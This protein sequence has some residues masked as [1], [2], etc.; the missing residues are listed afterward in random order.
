[1]PVDRY[2][3]SDSARSAGEPAIRNAV[4]SRAAAILRALGETADSGVSTTELARTLGLP[5]ATVHRLMVALS[6]EGLVD[7][8]PD[9][10]RWVLGLEMYVL[11]ST[12]ALRYDIATAAGE[13]LRNLARATGESAF[14]SVRRGDETVVLTD[15]EGTF[16]LRSHVLHPGKRLPLGVASA[17]LVLLA[18]LPDAEVDRYLDHVDLAAGWGPK[19]SAANVRRRLAETRRLGYSVNPGLLVEGSWGIG[20]A[21][22]NRSGRPEWALSLTGVQTRFSASRR[23]QLGESLLRAAH[24]LTLR[25]R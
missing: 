8:S 24:D 9:T 18:H 20:A 14:L 17:G 1:M 3:S 4:I 2:Q 21:V 23:P 5:R 12:T 13:I 16:P 25:I 22:F 7:R 15:A 10:G 19:H 6:E 11:G